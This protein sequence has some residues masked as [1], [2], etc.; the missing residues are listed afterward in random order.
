MFYFL[1]IRRQYG[2]FVRACPIEPFKHSWF[3]K[4]R[5]YTWN[6]ETNL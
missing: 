6:L 4:P 1:L 2:H 3:I 5:D